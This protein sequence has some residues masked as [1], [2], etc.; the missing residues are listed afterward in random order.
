MRKRKEK[1]T[2]FR[3]GKDKNPKKE[4]NTGV[5]KGFQ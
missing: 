1:K 3:V 4:V 2:T 5:K